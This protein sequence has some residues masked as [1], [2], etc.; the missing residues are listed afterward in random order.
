MVREGEKGETTGFFFLLRFL[1]RTREKGNRRKGDIGRG[2]SDREI[3]RDDGRVPRA[4]AE[5][6]TVNF[7]RI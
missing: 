2:C 5:S 7:R 3:V 6:L 4:T 1:D